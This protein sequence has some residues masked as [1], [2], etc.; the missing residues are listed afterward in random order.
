MSQVVRH[1]DRPSLAIFS[2]VGQPWVALP[3]IMIFLGAYAFCDDGPNMVWDSKYSD[4]VEPNT[5]EH[6]HAIEFLTHTIQFFGL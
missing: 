6:E 5:N 2:K 3:M 4:W 1:N